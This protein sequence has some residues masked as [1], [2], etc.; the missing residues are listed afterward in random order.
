MKVITP[1]RQKEINPLYI[2]LVSILIYI[3][4]N[5]TGIANTL[6]PLIVGLEPISLTGMD[7]GRTIKEKITGVLNYE[8]N[9]S[10]ID[11][12]K[13]KIEQLEVKA[14]EY[15]V[16]KKKFEALEQ[17]AKSSDKSYEYIQTSFYSPSDGSSLIIDAGKSDGVNIGDV[18]VLGQSYIGIV[19]NVGETSSEVITPDSSKSSLEVIITKE[20]KS[21]TIKAIA[22]GKNFEII[23]ENIAGNSNVS[24]GDLVFISDKRIGGKLFLG[25]VTQ[26]VKDD[27]ASV[28]TAKVKPNIEI[29]NNNYI[30][31]RK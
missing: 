16:L 12:L 29:F 31:V 30:F 19:E 7:I 6:S 3:F 5:V 14:G 9:L 2:V 11:L 26:L 18:V 24:D 22:V 20:G 23:I 21:S 28:L 17:H 4:G 8:Q 25:R 15:E 27:A 1:N 10:S 13:K